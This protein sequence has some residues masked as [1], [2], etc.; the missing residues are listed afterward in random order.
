MLPMLHTGQIKTLRSRS[1]TI[2]R[3]TSGL[4]PD[5]RTHTGRA[6]TTVADLKRPFGEEQ[7]A[8]ISRRAITHKAAYVAPAVLAVIAASHRPALAASDK[9]GIIDTLKMTTVTMTIVI[10]IDI[11]T[12][13]GPVYPLGCHDSYARH[14]ARC[15]SHLCWANRS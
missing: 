8:E 1:G 6:C 2:R 4:V 14:S 12:I 5:V 13:E 3:R 11:L 10:S 15:E 7:A 9:I